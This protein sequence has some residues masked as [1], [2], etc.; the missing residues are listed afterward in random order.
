MSIEK[1]VTK[2]I[3]FSAKVNGKPATIAEVI[4]TGKEAEFYQQNETTKEFEK[5][6]LHSQTT[7][8][9]AILSEKVWE[10][11]EQEALLEEIRS[12][13]KAMSEKIGASLKPKGSPTQS[14][15]PTRPDV[16]SPR[17]VVPE[18]QETPDMAEYNK[19]TNELLKKFNPSAISMIPKTQQ[20]HN[21]P[22]KGTNTIRM[23]VFSDSDKKT[24]GNT[25]QAYIAELQQMAKKNN[26]DLVLGTGDHVY[27]RGTR[28]NEIYQARLDKVRKEFKGFGNTPLAITMGNHDIN[29]KGK[30]DKKLFDENKLE[31]YDQLAD[32]SAYSYTLGGATFVVFNEGSTSYSDKQI[33]FFKKKSMEGNG[34]VYLVNHIPPFQDAFGAGLREDGK[35][36]SKN[37]K[38]IQQFTK[39]NLENKGRPFYIISGDTHFGHVIGNFLNPGAT[40]ANYFGLSGKRLQTV[41]S[42]AVVDMDA[43]TGKIKAVYFRSAQSGFEAPLPPQQNTLAWGGRTN[44]DIAGK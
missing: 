36:S 23:A 2:A 10:I 33:A 41:P 16:T 39:T 28:T 17:T 30:T 40:G 34:A 25:D 22:P 7:L 43:T 26:V 5:L 3:K 11:G 29:D 35:R 14:A 20:S 9:I 42:A 38:E 27:D 19:K 1:P 18:T 44:R 13:R 31:N 6:E 8:N 24:R 37:F 4:H 15:Q 32:A 12:Q 21:I